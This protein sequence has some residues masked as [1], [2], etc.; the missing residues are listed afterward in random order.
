MIDATLRGK[1]LNRLLTL[2]GR[3]LTFIFF[4]IL[5]PSLDFIL[6]ID[7]QEK[8]VLKILQYM[9]ESELHIWTL[10]GLKT[11]SIT[12]IDLGLTLRLGEER[13]IPEDRAR[14]SRDLSIALAN[15][16]VERTKVLSV[17]ADNIPYA[18]ASAHQATQVPSPLHKHKAPSPAQE[19]S[20][21]RLDKIEMMLERLLEQGLA[22]P[23]SS[24]HQPSQQPPHIPIS[25]EGVAKLDY[26]EDDY[27]PAQFIPTKIRSSDIKV[28][29]EL[30]G[31]AVRT[32][33]SEDQGTQETIELLKSLKS[34]KVS[35]T[36]KNVKK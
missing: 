1:V 22:A 27:V 2:I 8:D 20:S 15:K 11:P 21:P 28:D 31:G 34:T 18:H 14:N 33:T 16:S 12:L 23:T 25:Q 35:P 19:V 4:P 26:E 30:V 17:Y 36:P 7:H 29:S 32:N 5:R 3:F 6:K 13:S 24:T 9:K 10:K